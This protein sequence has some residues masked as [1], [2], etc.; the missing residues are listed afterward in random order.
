MTKNNFKIDYRKE[1]NQEQYKV[2]T[3][4]DGPC[5]VLAGAGSGKTRTLVYRVAYL[6]E[7]GVDPREILLVTFTN[8][9]AS[10]MMGRINGLVKGQTQGL[11][12]G[13]FHHIGNR[14]LRQYGQAIGIPVNFKI[15]DAE[16]SKA[17]IKLCYKNA[18]L[19]EDKRFP[20]ADLIHKVISLSANLN[21][22]LDSVLK[23]R[24]SYLD[25]SHLSIISDIAKD[26][27]NRKKVNNSLDFDDL[28]VEWNN[29][30]GSSLKI[31]NK[32]AQ[33]FKYILVD[34]YQDTNPIQG[35]IVIHL[36]GAEENVLVVGDDS[37]SIYSFRGADV[38]NILSFPEIFKQTKIFRLETN[39]R[40]TPEILSLANKIIKHNRRQFDKKLKTH[41]VSS[42]K[43]VLIKAEDN[44]AQ[45]KFICGQIHKM[46]TEGLELEQIAILF[47]AHFQSLELELELNKQGIAYVMRGGLRFFEQAHI[48]DVLAY[49]RILADFHDQISWQR[50][51]QFYPG[52]G[53]AMAERLWLRI[54]EMSNIKEV[55]QA[56]LAYGLPI[57]VSQ[58]WN[59]AVKIFEKLLSLEPG[60]ISAALAE[61]VNYQYQ[62]Y[63]KIN[64]DNYQDRL[65]DLD[66]LIDFAA[67]YDSLESFLT[68]T[69]LGESFKKED[70][71]NSEVKHRPAVT[72]STI[73]QAK[74]LEWKM[75]FVIGLA[76]GQFPNAKAFDRLVDLEEERRLFYVAVTR[77]EDRLFLL[78]PMF[79]RYTGD[80]NDLSQFIKELPREV[81]EAEEADD[82][83]WSQLNDDSQ[84]VVYIN[85]ENDDVSANFWQRMAKYRDQ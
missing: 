42:I 64:Y 79:S 33:K 17:L 75:V 32:L 84:D 5:L 51:L 61:I 65:A 20:K 62:D 28:L 36:A 27:Q 52:I 9:A 59:E 3:E 77:A 23:Q 49:L 69:A 7:Q 30:L 82:F 60:N 41:K 24:F 63:L 73:H 11:W 76:E 25:P 38:N 18:R 54:N 80:L 37:Q 13:T 48:K 53:G 6:L 66:Q 78:Y 81:Y 58:A 26:Y 50:I 1:L 44:I 35:S 15:I 19:P 14:V 68:D 29:L 57:K 56:D 55:V 2:V 71:Q 46:Q 70:I 45:A 10:E 83:N 8:K 34:E 31:K 21:Q 67:G 43:P 12:G 74:G 47:R 39:Y 40:S 85:E 4:G 22:P 16:D 72:L